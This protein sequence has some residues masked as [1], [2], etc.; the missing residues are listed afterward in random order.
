LQS[1]R[2]FLQPMC[3]KERGVHGAGDSFVEC[4]VGPEATRKTNQNRHKTGVALRRNKRAKSER[5]GR[6]AAAWICG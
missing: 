2:D 4:P 5:E 1:R 3:V 6:E